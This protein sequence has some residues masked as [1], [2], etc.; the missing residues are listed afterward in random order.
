MMSLKS[1]SRVNKKTTKKNDLCVYNRVYT[2]TDNVGKTMVMCVMDFKGNAGL[3]SKETTFASMCSIEND[4][5]NKRLYPLTI[6]SFNSAY[7]LYTKNYM[8]V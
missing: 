8:L 7:A 6:E 2:C 4:C 3:S 5:V 1:V